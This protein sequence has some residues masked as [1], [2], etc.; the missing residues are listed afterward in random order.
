MK[1]S[2]WNHSRWTTNEI[3]QKRWIF[4]DQPNSKV[5][6]E[7]AQS[8]EIGES[9]ATLLAQRGIDTFEEAKTFFRPSLQA[10]LHDPFLMQDMDK[11]VTRLEKA[12]KNLKEI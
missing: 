1:R 7:L 4:K 3:M 10:H 2:A 8:L 5:V 6:K 11:A 9:M 12:L